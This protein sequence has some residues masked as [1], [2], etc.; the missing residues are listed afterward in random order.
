MATPST[1]NA[2]TSET[3]WRWRASRFCSRWG[4]R[5]MRMAFYRY[6]ALFEAAHGEAGCDHQHRRFLRELTG[7]DAIGRLHCPKWIRDDRCNTCALGDELVQTGQQCTAAGKDDLI[8]LVVRRR[9]EEELQRARHLE[10]QRLHERLQDV[11]VVVF[12]QA[13]VLARRFGFFSGQIEGALNVL[14]KLIAAECLVA[15]E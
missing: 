13:L 3:N 11:V 1:A 2:M 15:R 8:H 7:A 14:R 5:L 12:G 4:S 6:R 9:R 10:R